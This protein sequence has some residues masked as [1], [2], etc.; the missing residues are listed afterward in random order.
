MKRKGIDWDSVALGSVPDG[1]IAYLFG[2]SSTC[3]VD[4]RHRRRIAPCC[5]TPRTIRP[6]VRVRR[7]IVDEYVLLALERNYGPLRS[8]EIHDAVINDY[9]SVAHRTII[10]RLNR[11][12]E[13]GRIV[14]LGDTQ[15]MRRYTRRK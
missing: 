15:Q 1:F 2:V 13:S 3:V 5:P 6:M 9:G 11:L 12:V 7:S 4:V 8:G 14:M 10:R